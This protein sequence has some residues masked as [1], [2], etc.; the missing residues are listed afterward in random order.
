MT[1]E[2]RKNHLWIN[3][4]YP[5]MLICQFC[6]R[7]SLYNEYANLGH[8]YTRDKELWLELCPSCHRLLDNSNINKIFNP[9]KTSGV[10]L[11]DKQKKEVIIYGKKV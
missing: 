1:S 8:N 6:S 4:N 3:K 10:K 11:W 5:K 7:I 9:E 2:N